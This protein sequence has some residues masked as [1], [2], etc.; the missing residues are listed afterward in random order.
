MRAGED[1][2]WAFAAAAHARILSGL[3]RHAEAQARAEG[4][5]QAA[6]AADLGYVK[7][8]IRM[9]L[10]VAT[11]HMGEMHLAAHHA[12][13][14]LTEFRN[15]GS[16]GLNVALAHETRVQVAVLAGDRASAETHLNELA[17]ELRFG[18]NQTLNARYERLRSMSR[19]TFLGDSRP[20]QDEPV[21]RTQIIAALTG[22]EGTEERA[23]RSLEI[24]L[25]ETGS[26]QGFLYAITSDGCTLAA[27]RADH[28]LPAEIDAIARKSLAQEL[29]DDANTG[30]IEDSDALT[31]AWSTGD[32]RTY[33]SV[34]LGHSSKRG[35]VV[36]GLGVLL[37]DPNVP[38]K[39]VT[40]IA[41]EISRY[42]GLQRESPRLSLAP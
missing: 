9:A 14:V 20:A 39:D 28:A 33:R 29:H 2:L 27:S 25:A 12:D 41:T 26:T 18:S 24:L 38:M 37:C 40:Q 5:L 10:A 6:S 8:Y 30:E 21:M 32:G 35:F 42:A 34:L 16:Q 13:Q 15:M 3:G 1:Q 36:T 23:Q 31:R 4:H 7:N 19:R 11:A 22:C 17:S